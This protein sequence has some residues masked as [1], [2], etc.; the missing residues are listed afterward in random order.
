[1]IKFHFGVSLHEVGGFIILCLMRLLT[2]TKYHKSHYLNFLKFVYAYGSF[3]CM[4]VCYLYVWCWQH[5][6]SGEGSE[7]QELKCGC[8]GR[9]AG[10]VSPALHGLFQ[11]VTQKH[12]WRV[13]ELEKCFLMPI[14]KSSFQVF[15]LLIFV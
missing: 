1:M 4:S 7:G 2:C 15:Y 11:I 9:A 14:L 8:P 13:L 3:I 12:G 5:Q 6:R 10:T